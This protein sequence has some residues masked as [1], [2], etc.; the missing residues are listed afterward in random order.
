MKIFNS[1]TNK[2]EEFVPRHKGKVNMYVCGPTVYNHIHIGNARPV[3]FFDT[4]RRYFE[5]RGYEVTYASNFTDVDDRIIN[6]ALQLGKSEK[7]ITEY[8]IDEFLKAVKKV[9]SST[10]YIQP[11]VTNY[12][13]HIIEYI[14]LLIDKGYAYQIDGDVYFRVDSVKEYGM[15]SNRKLDDM[16]S[17]ARIEINE[18]KENPLDFTLWKKTDVGIQF[19][20]PFGEGRPGWHTECVAMIDD[21]FGE[22]IDIHGG[23]SGLK[24][25]HHENEIA[26]SLALNN[27]TI[28]RYWMHNG[29]LNIGGSKMSKSEGK[30]VL[31]KDLDIDPNVF[32]L[33]TLSTHYRSPIEY[34]DEVLMNYEKEWDKYLRIYKAIHLKLDLEDG[35]YNN[36]KIDPDLLEIYK[37]FL[38]AMDQDF[39]TAN[40]ITAMQDLV[41]KANQLY[42]NKT[43]N[44]V[45]LSVLKI[46]DDFFDILGLY[47]HVK[48]LEKD[49]KEV[50]L[51]WVNARK[52]KDFDAAD[53]YRAILQEKGII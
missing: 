40:A 18:K 35:L 4:V 39:N 49:D 38:D 13:D 45:L 47:P 46:F 1:Y 19:D 27:H 26:H 50:Y 12:M 9:N 28:A 43:E 34:T 52:E 2:L 37:R 32:R 21:I 41:K 3:I 20:S 53:K 22:E 14:G 17:G 29:L 5:H 24:F 8:Y 33:F 48:P 31:V 42:R 36:A 7:E 16:I 25:P 15:L 30:T 11:K 10:D 44:E 6:T 23:G 51:K